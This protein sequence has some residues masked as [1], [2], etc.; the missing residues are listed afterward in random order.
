MKKIIGIAIGLL[1]I[2]GACSNTED[3][4][5]S[6][7]EMDMATEEDS[8]MPDTA[9][10]NDSLSEGEMNSDTNNITDNVQEQMMVYNADVSLRTRDY[11][12]FY[13]QLESHIDKQE[14]YI[15]EANVHKMEQGQRS[16]NIRIRVPQENFRPFIDDLGSYSDNIDSRNI[17]GRDVTEEYVDL[18]SRLKA[19][20]KIEE[21][22]LTFMDDAEKTEDL[23][24]ISQDLER[25]QEEI[26]TIKG[27][28]NYLENQSDFSTVSLTI[29]E[30]KVN[31]PDLKDQDLNT[32]EK[33]KQAFVQSLN[34]L[35][36]AASWIVVAL[37]GYSPILVLLAI[38][39]IWWLLRRRKHRPTDQK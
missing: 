5:E 6:N 14:A 8:S 31:V 20:E 35:T 7:E 22:L 11:D 28:M 19:K 37:I 26:E 33:T 13:E 2:L 36:Q 39:L 24:Q 4:S 10:K 17:S 29:T 25:V 21:R 30:T 27:K 32:W 23:I 18:E 15:I 38:P 34:G 12:S 9:Q 1:L 16:A 3:R